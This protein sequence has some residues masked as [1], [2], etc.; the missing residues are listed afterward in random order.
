[1]ATFNFSPFAMKTRLRLLLLITAATLVACAPMGDRGRPE[2]GPPGGN[3]MGGGM[4]G[5]AASNVIDLIAERLQK[6]A[7]ALKLTPKQAVLWDAYQDKVGALMTDQMK[8]QP[9]RAVQGPAPK[10]IAG[11]ID[12][13]RNRLAA[14]E[15]IQDAANKLYAALDDD[16]K[17]IADQMLPATVPALYSGLGGGASGGGEQRGS[18]NSRGGPEG[19]MGG[20]GGGMG[21]GMGGGFGRM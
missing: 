1:M 16:Q 2:G 7:E 6:T 21:G 8:L 5:E 10:Q 13:V 15:D 20:P 4:G 3:G 14:M 11:K 19:G 18:R 9:Y 12:V 17:K